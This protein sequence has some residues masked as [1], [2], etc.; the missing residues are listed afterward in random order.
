[1]DTIGKR[2]RHWRTS[3]NLTTSEVA[4]K[5]GISQSVLS[6]YENDKSVIGGKA[7]IYLYQNFDIDIQWLLT[8]D[9]SER[10]CLTEN[11]QELLESFQLL[12]ER[13]QIKFIA[14]VE[15]AAAPYRQ[16]SEKSSESKTG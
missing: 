1:M 5:A 10:N 16:S 13:E 3:N 9:Y 7:L 6:S 14:R 2:L 11:E 4:E 12:P 8:G 15:D